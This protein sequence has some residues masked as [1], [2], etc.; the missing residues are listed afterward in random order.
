MT[1]NDCES[2]CTDIVDEFVKDS[3]INAKKRGELIQKL[4]NGTMKSE[5]WI[6]LADLRT[7]DASNV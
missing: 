4:K 6:L 7:E 1:S 2:V 3:L 5:D